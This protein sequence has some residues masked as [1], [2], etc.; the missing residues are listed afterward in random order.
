MD[1]KTLFK[2]SLLSEQFLFA[3]KL[4][5]VNYFFF[6]NPTT[7]D[8]ADSKSDGNRGF[9]D[10]DG[11]L[12]MEAAIDTT[13]SYLEHEAV[14]SVLEK[15][16]YLKN[17]PAMWHLNYKGGIAVLRKGSTR[18]FELSESVHEVIQAFI[19]DDPRYEHA[20]KMY[21]PMINLTKG[22][23]SGEYQLNEVIIPIL[24]RC[25]QKNSTYSFELDF[26]NRKINI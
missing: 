5:G 13:R 1:I 8:F 23:K 26:R 11:N 25:K 15:K 14:V 4:A 21:K 19:D 18:T 3:E 9:V 17:V 24:K 20:R 16:G 6:K 22:W 10:T 12:F 2:K 7:T